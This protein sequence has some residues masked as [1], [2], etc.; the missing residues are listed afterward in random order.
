MRKIIPL[1]SLVLLL[2]TACATENSSKT[3]PSTLYT[4]YSQSVTK[5]QSLEILAP[6]ATDQSET[7]VRSKINDLALTEDNINLCEAATEPQSCRDS[8]LYL[9]A[10][11]QKD[12]AYCF[13][14]SRID[15][16][17]ACQKKVQAQ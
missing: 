14:L 5:P 1:L 9:K 17:Q 15:D 7:C 16:V 11:T 4:S 13:K 6:C 2:L 3:I 8:Y 10:V 12:P